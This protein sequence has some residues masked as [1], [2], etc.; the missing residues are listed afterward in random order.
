LVRLSGASCFLCEGQAVVGRRR[1]LVVICGVDASRLSPDGVTDA[2]CR[3]LVSLVAG[4]A[5]CMLGL[6]VG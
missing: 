6:S 5:R 3:R 4:L 2:G 1:T